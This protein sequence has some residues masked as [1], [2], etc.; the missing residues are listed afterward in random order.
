MKILLISRGCPSIENPMNGNFEFDQAVAL[1]SLGHEVIL[2][3]V[4]RRRNAINRK[5][6]ISKETVDGIL[7]YKIFLMPLPIRFCLLFTTFIASVLGLFLFRKIVKDIGLPD[8]IH[9]HYLYNHPIAIK[10]KKKYSIPVVLTEHWSVLNF[11]KIPS[12][13]RKLA[14]RTYPFASLVI[15]VSESLRKSIYRITAVDSVVINNMVD[16][17]FFASKKS[18]AGKSN[19]HFIFITVGSLAPVKNY[20]LLIESFALSSFSE[21]VHLYIV[22]YG[23]E[24]DKLKMLISSRHLDG[25]IF[26]LGKKNRCEIRDLLHNADAFVL[27]SKSETFG[28]VLIEAMACGLPVISTKCGG[29]EEF[30]NPDVGYLVDNNDVR[31]LSEAM[32]RM[33]KESKYFEADDIYDYCKNKFSN[34]VIVE[35]L[36]ALYENLL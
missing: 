18:L 9:S 23:R 7:V 11:S 33:Y 30:V 13:V 1:K 28:V 29:P 27:S 19:R 24:F 31:L 15:S 21:N 22:G 34:K 2:L 32:K 6:G 12:S 10:I 14:Y 5:L 17:D 16:I 8:I 35:Q 20:E 26:L 4:D 25:Q 36:N 3:C